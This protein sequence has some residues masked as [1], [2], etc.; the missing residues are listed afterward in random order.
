MR[1]LYLRNDWNGHP[2]RK[3][4]VND[5]T[6][7]PVPT[8]PEKLSD[9]QP[10]F[11]AGQAEAENE[12]HL[13]EKEEYVV[14]IGPQHPATHGVLHFQVSLE[15]EVVRKVDPHCGYIHRGIEKM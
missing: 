13:F 2:L 11:H 10:V 9:D 5:P 15:G 12:G 8:K 14:N 3:D 7:N 1:R 6:L 4:Y